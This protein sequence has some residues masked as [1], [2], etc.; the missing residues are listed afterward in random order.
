VTPALLAS[1][2]RVRP[3]SRRAAR[4]CDAMCVGGFT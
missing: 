3:A 2:S 4:T 1:C